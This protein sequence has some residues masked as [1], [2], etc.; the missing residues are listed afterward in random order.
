M[1][2]DGAVGPCLLEY[3]LVEGGALSNRASKQNGQIGALHWLSSSLAQKPRGKKFCKTLLQSA[4]PQ[5]SSRTIGFQIFMQHELAH[6]EKSKTTPR[7]RARL[8]ALCQKLLSTALR[9]TC[10][11]LYISLALGH[12]S[13]P[14][15]K[16]AWWFASWWH[17]FFCSLNTGILVCQRTAISR[18]R[19]QLKR[20]QGLC[21][22]S[23]FFNLPCRVASWESGRC[24]CQIIFVR[25]VSCVT[26]P[27]KESA[28]VWK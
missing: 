17:E 3:Q 13:Q 9:R 23:L 8:T 27:R 12:F 25:T 7:R 5:H 26:Q 4:P 14:A 6:L 18:P 10:A 21:M 2:V 20:V 1:D 15:S 16:L 19:C 24:A 22:C 11:A 28:G